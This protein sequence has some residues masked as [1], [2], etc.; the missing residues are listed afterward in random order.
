MV[1]LGIDYGTTNTVAVLYDRGH[2]PVV[3]HATDTAIGPISREV[4]PSIAVRDRKTGVFHF[5]AEA[6]R[7]VARPGA[8]A[9]YDVLRSLKRLIR[10][11]S[12]GMLLGQDLI[13]GGVDPAAVLK[14]FLSTLRSSIVR[15]GFIRPGEKLE[16]VITWPANA[17]GAQRYLTRRCFREA[18]FD[19]VGSLTE[20]AAAAIEFADRISHGNRADARKLSMRFCVIDLGGGTF[21]VSLMKMEGRDFT[22]IDATGIE[23]LGG[24]DLDEILARLF[25]DRLDMAFDALEPFQKI[26]LLNH[27]RQQKES[28]SSG[29][30]RSLTLAAEDMGLGRGLVSVSVDLFYKAATQQLG[31]AMEKAWELLHGKAAKEAGISLRSL[32]AIYLAGGSSRLP[33]VQEM[34]SR[35]FPRVRLV[36]SD[37]PFSATA[38]GAAIHSQEAIRMQEILSRHFGV[39]RLADHG[40]QEYFDPIFAAGTPLPPRTG[41]AI[42]RK[43][44][45]TPRH[46]IG[47]LRYLECAAVDQRRLPKEGVREWSD[48]LFPYDPCLDVGALFSADQIEVRDDLHEM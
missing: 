42:E 39:M 3:L 27:S 13:P 7:L 26:L 30:V 1:R 31:P 8:E 23:Q 5:G 36:T 14:D 15:S 4:F 45:Y 38:M 40:R 22:V 46:N 47:H 43:L 16:A 37:K 48:T 25:L 28:I 6:E 32:D 11:F 34:V 33:L 9:R 29:L 44:V 12:E 17:N 35:R 21:D 20:P 41:K 24:D 18:G 10:D 19:V 2:Y